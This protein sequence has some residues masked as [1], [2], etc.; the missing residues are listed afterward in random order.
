MLSRS[1]TVALR[2]SVRGSLLFLL[3]VA[4]GLGCRTEPE[5]IQGHLEGTI[6]VRAS[7]D[8]SGDY[9]DFRVLVVQAGGRS[10]DTLGQAVTGPDGT[11]EM[12]VQAPERG[13]YPLTVWGRQGQQRL[14]STD[15]VVAEGDTARL[16]VELPVERGRLRV[17][18][19]E[20]AAL[21][22]YRNTVA[23][24]RR[25]LVRQIQTETV[26]STTLDRSVR[27]TS[28]ILWSLRETFPGTYAS[29]LAAVESLSLLAG[30]NDS[31]VVERT[32]SI[33]PS[34]P[35][36]VEA[37][38]LARRAEA[39]LRGQEAALELLAGFENRAVTNEQRAGVQSLRVQS[40]IDS[41]QAKAALSAAQR[42]KNEYPNTQWAEWAD[43]ATYEV[44]NLLPGSE[45][46]PLRARTVDG[47]SL[48]LRGLRGRPVVL[49]YFRP[50]NDL[51]GRQ[52]STRTALYRSTR[53]D[54]VA[55]VSVSVDPDTLVYQAFTEG[56]PF[57]GHAV[58]AP[59]GLDDP[60]VTA[61]NVA[62]VP[63]RVLIDADGDI[64]GRYSG[65][66]LLALQEDLAR[67]LQE[68]TASRGAGGASP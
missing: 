8:S 34:N 40:F 50:G 19:E 56:R 46:P 10:I 9:S 47:D 44:N 66:A 23:Q 26:A 4:I 52:L 48:S 58:I 43:R 60:L 7:I 24:H 57:P 31:L 16:E 36:Y 54:S 61:Y 28:S 15:Y 37:A 25:T 51:Y 20:N 64:V 49:E 14:A 6:T 38:R 27:Q 3:M 12:T 22:A 55:F 2:S 1:T 59:E 29:Q 11:F 39:R 13:I 62:D 53:A 42:L 21:M 33:E 67:L 17:R 68:T 18:S 45:A 30:R 41:L 32:Q 35:R 5:G 65:T 63:S